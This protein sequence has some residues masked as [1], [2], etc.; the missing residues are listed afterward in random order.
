MALGYLFAVLNMTINSMSLK[1]MENVLE[2]DYGCTGINH[3]TLFSWRHKLIHALAS[4]PMPKLSGVIQVDE[5]FVREA[6]KGSRKLV[7][8]LDKTDVREPRY[9]RQPS[10]FGVMG[11]EFATVTTA[12]DN[13]GYSASKVSCLGKLTT[14]LFTTLFEEHLYDASY[15]C[16]NA[17]RVYEEYC[18]L[19]NIAH[20]I[21]PSNYM[22]V[23]EHN[24][25]KTPSRVDPA[26]AKI[27]RVENKKLLERLYKDKLIDLYLKPRIFDL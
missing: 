18:K 12:I 3:K 6:Q 13:H 26:K 21:K 11:S 19:L 2:K 14:D 7:S 10:K 22:T 9:G 20:Y 27:T 25:Y 8:Y 1:E 23:L 4:P 5:T 16:S 17:N 15:I 24:G